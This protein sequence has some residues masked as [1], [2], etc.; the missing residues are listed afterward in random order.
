M[1][2]GEQEGCVFNDRI[3]LEVSPS[4]LE[5]LIE[6]TRKKVMEEENYNFVWI[7]R[8]LKDYLQNRYDTWKKLRDEKDK[9][10]K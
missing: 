2:L 7:Y 4:K 3:D 1:K 5:T 10:P 9:G 8:D 6:L